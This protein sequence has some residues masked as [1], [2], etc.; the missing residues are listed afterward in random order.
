MQVPLSKESKHKIAF[1][2]PYGTAEFERMTFGLVNAP[3]EFIKLMNI[4]LGPLRNDIAMCYLDENLIPAV[5]WKQMSERLKLVLEKLKMANLTLKLDKCE[6]GKH[7]VNFLDHKLTG[8]GLQ[9]G[10]RK[11]L[12]IEKFPTPGSLFLTV[13]RVLA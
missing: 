13:E 5:D 8:N 1:I 2:T 11:L 12:A 7:E 4:V 3:Y 10:G 9:P 6:F